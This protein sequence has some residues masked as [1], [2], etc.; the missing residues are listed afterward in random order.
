MGLQ[1]LVEQSLSLEDPIAIHKIK[2]KETDISEECDKGH[3]SG[4]NMETQ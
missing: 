2:I 3:S 4:K 1:K